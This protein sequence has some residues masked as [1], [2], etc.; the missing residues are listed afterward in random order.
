MPWMVPSKVAVAVP[1]PPVSVSER[2]H[3]AVIIDIELVVGLPFGGDVAAILC[4]GH[5]GGGAA[6]IDGT[7]ADGGEN[8]IRRCY[9]VRVAFFAASGKADGCKG[10]QREI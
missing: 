2:V 1:A 6:L 10:K 7:D 4:V 9:K 8:L 3:M 5:T